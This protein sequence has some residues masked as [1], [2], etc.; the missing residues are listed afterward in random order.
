MLPRRMGGSQRA[1]F[2]LA[3]ELWRSIPHGAFQRILDQLL[4][5]DA[6][7]GQFRATGLL[8][9]RRILGR[10]SGVLARIGGQLLSGGLQL[11]SG[12]IRRT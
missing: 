1:A 10:V 12:A 7:S 6:D 3:N 5:L 2:L 8:G 9:S 4:L 11:G